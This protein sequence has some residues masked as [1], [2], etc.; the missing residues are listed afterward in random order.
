MEEENHNLCR[1]FFQILP[2]LHDLYPLHLFYLTIL[3]T[4]IV[5]LRFTKEE[6]E[7][8]ILTLYPK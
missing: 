7:V 5:I 6:A 1:V 4:S 3:V 2:N 8:R